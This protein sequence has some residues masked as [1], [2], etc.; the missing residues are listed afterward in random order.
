MKKLNKLFFNVIFIVVGVLV[1]IATLS[2]NFKDVVNTL[3]NIRVSWLFLAIFITFLWQF[4]YWFN[5]SCL[6]TLLT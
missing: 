6:N 3:V 4:F 1:I 2:S 5:F